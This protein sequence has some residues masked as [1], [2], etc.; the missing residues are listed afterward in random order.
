MTA[1]TQETDAFEGMD[2][3]SVIEAATTELMDDTPADVNTDDV[4]TDDNTDDAPDAAPVDA[5]AAVEV[6]TPK[7]VPFEIRTNAGTYVVP[8]SRFDEKAKTIAF[9]DSRS[10]QKFLNLCKEG[11]EYQ[12]SGKNALK[13]MRRALEQKEREPDE[14]KVQAQVYLQ[15]FKAL[16]TMSEQE[17]YDFCMNARMNWPKIE[18]KAERQYAE[19]L[20]QQARLAQEPP[21]PDVEQIVEEATNGVSRFIQQTLATEAWA[22]DDVRDEL[23]AILSDRNMLSQFVYK[24]PRDEPSFGVRRGQWVADWDK[25]TEILTQ[26][27]KPYQRAAQATQTATQRVQTTQAVA[28]TNARALARAKPTTPPVAPQKK[29]AP[30]RQRPQDVVKDAMSVWREMNAR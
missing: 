1:P 17:L 14:E 16:M 12:Q 8:N 10:W 23:T 26:L 4:L 9:D 24:S 22:T 29:A 3:D 21:E 28:Q 15:E 6:E 2:D 18:A 11:R 20:H 25:A 27:Q 30:P 5:V 7:Y 19:R 13:E